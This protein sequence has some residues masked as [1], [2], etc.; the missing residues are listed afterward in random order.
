MYRRVFLVTESDEYPIGTVGD[1]LTEDNAS[2]AHT[3]SSVIRGI[4]EEIVF[5]DLQCKAKQIS[6][7]IR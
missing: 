1:I 7:Q 5:D 3:A 2:G 6:I 4:I